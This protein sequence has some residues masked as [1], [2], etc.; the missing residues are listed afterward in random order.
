[1]MKRKGAVSSVFVTKR[2]YL[3]QAVPPTICC[4]TRN[5]PILFAPGASG[6]KT[7][8]EKHHLFP[9]AWLSRKGISKDRDRN[10]IANFAYIEWKDN[11]GISDEEPAG[12]RKRLSG[13][14]SNADMRKMMADN[15]L[16]DNG[17]HLDYFAFLAERRKRMARIIRRGYERLKQGE[18]V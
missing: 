15:A 4:S 17:F 7:A 9:K 10:Q 14:F 18:V 11:L 16:P 13:H 8:I 2:P 12:Y 5:L 6:T 3:F 1:M